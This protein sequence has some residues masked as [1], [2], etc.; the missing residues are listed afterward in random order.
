[1]RLSI[2]KDRHRYAP[3]MYPSYGVLLNDQTRQYVMGQARL[4]TR[5]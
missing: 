3:V 4:M 5:V 1:M 2:I